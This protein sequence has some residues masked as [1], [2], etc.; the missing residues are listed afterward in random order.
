[1]PAYFGAKIVTFLFVFQKKKSWNPNSPPK[2]YFLFS[3]PEWTHNSHRMCTFRPYRRISLCRI[4]FRSPE[5][6]GFRGCTTG[7]NTDRPQ[8]GNSLHRLSS[9]WRFFKLR[10]RRHQSQTLGHSPKRLHFH[11]QRPQRN[12]QLSQIQSGWAVGGLGWG[13]G[14]S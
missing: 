14:C 3:E 6:L 9:L 2:L 12:H 8:I 10:F 13:R 7:A 1:M 4:C 5:N 11:L